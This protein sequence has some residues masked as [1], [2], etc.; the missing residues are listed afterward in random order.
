M[1]F[2]LFL[3][4]R[5]GFLDDLC[6]GAP[7]TLWNLRESSCSTRQRCLEGLTLPQLS[8]GNSKWDEIGRA[9]RGSGDVQTFMGPI[10]S[11]RVGSAQYCFKPHRSSQVGPR[12]DGKLAGLVRGHGPRE[13]GHPCIPCADPTLRFLPASSP[14][15]SLAPIL[16]N[17]YVVPDAESRH[18]LLIHP[19]QLQP[20]HISP[21]GAN[22]NILSCL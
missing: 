22:V 8:N 16:N 10:G 9:L 15:V 20:G 4:S 3:P 14:C 6:A 17:T 7:D 11:S 12:G 19:Y 2:A 21:R 5:F 18:A 1:A 13:T